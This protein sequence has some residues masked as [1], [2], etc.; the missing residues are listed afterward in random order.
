MQ[1][2]PIRLVTCTYDSPPR[3]FARGRVPFWD[4]EGYTPPVYEKSKEA[5]E[6]EK[7]TDLRKT[8]VNKSRAVNGLQ[9]PQFEN[10][11]VS[12]RADFSTRG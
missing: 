6:N 1:F 2:A 9:H 8:G 4:V 5:L 3:A 10:V 11:T 7:V 12:A